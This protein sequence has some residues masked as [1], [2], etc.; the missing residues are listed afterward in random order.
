MFNFDHSFILISSV[1][2]TGEN[3]EIIPKK[4]SQWLKMYSRQLR[5]TVQPFTALLYAYVLCNVHTQP[6]RT[7]PIS[8]QYVSIL[9]P[10]GTFH[11][12]ST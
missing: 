7:A 2:V 4:V 3:N 9:Q 10:R 1:A 6:S 5:R 12:F 8:C 11:R